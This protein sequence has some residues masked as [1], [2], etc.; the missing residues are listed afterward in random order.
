MRTVM[1]FTVFGTEV[2]AD[3]PPAGEVTDMTGKALEQGKQGK[4]KNQS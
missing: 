3:A 2:E 1:E 4:G